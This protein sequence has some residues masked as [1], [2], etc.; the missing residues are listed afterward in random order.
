MKRLTAACVPPSDTPR[1][2]REDPGVH[3]LA[4]LRRVAKPGSLIC[5]ISD[6][7]GV[8]EAA[9]HDVARLARHNDV[10]LVHVYDPLE[11]RLP[12][13]GR[14]RLTDGRAMVDLNSADV[15][16]AE[17]YAQRFTERRSALQELARRL[18]I[19]LLDAPTD[20]PPV[21]ALRAGLKQYR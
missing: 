19:R 11:T 9:R 17:R 15:L 10:M 21:A 16:I 13:P 12:P 2:Q 4:R 14:Y 20:I 1:S 18:H 6:F 5:L 8:I 7:R 3:A